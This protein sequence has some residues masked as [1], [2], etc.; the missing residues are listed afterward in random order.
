MTDRVASD[1]V[2]RTKGDNITN[3]TGGDNYTGLIDK[4]YPVGSI[5]I[6]IMS[7]NPGVTFGVGVWQ[8]F[9]TGRTLVGIDV[10]QTEF[11]TVGRTGGSKTHILSIA[12]MPKHTHICDN[13]APSATQG[14]NVNSTDRSGKHTHWIH[15]GSLPFEAGL[16]TP[17]RD[18]AY[19]FADNLRRSSVYFAHE[20]F[21]MDGNRRNSEHSHTL[22]SH[23]HALTQHNHINAETGGG[24]PHNNLQPY[25]TVYM[26]QR[27]S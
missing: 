23:T 7:T 22:S 21:T 4:V 14:P 1:T 13:A 3:N 24:I 17:D 9:G 8:T 10:N 12:E 6:T 16:N 11:N 20:D 27:I 19:S 5:Y 26:W 25:I 2:K 15:N 18:N